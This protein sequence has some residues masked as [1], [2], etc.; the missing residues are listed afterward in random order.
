MYPFYPMGDRLVTE[1]L[2]GCLRVAAPI[3]VISEVDIYS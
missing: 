3:K 2:Q 1:W